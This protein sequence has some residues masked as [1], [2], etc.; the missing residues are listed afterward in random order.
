MVLKFIY[1]L[2]HKGVKEENIPYYWKYSLWT[3]FVKPIRK[4]FSAAFIPY[5]PWNCVRIM[6]YRLCGYKIGKGVFIGMRCY[7]DDMCYDLMEIEDN[8]TISYGV[9]FACHGRGQKHQKLRIRKGAYIGM[10]TSIIAKKDL[11]IGENAI[12]GAMTLVDK[13][14][15]AG[16]TVVGVP[17]HVVAKS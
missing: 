10:R 2:T 1:K 16:E 5:L 12:V 4:W 6:L 17:C 8:V 15:G 13:S 3:V 11:D 7:L 9:F 14:V